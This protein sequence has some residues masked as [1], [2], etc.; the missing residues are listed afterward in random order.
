VVAI[1]APGAA[2]H[3]RYGFAVGKRVGGAVQRNRAKRL[4]REAARHLHPRVAPGHDIVFIARNRMSRA[5]T[6]AEVQ[7][8]MERALGQAGILDA[9]PVQDQ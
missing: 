2:P 3:N 9:E 5:T 6:F 7:E 8:A 1:V 4:M